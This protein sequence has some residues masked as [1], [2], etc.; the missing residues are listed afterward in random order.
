MSKVS[1]INIICLWIFEQNPFNPLVRHVSKQAL[2]L[3]AF[4]LYTDIQ[5]F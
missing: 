5:I 4:N 1:Y 2:Y 3:F